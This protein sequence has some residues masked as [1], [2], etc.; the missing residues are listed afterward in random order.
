MTPDG[1]L[2]V[3]WWM[4]AL[5]LAGSMMVW[6]ILGAAIA[7]RFGRR[8]GLEEGSWERRLPPVPLGE[9]GPPL[10]PLNPD[11]LIDRMILEARML[12]P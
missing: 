1:N 11:D 10:G 8:D 5:I 7:Y 4:L 3:P 9:D 2:I 6:M 12:E